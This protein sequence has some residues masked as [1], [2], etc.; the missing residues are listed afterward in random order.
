MYRKSLGS[1]STTV[2]EIPPASAPV[3]NNVRIFV[4]RTLEITVHLSPGEVMPAVAPGGSPLAAEKTPQCRKH[5]FLAALCHI[6]PVG[7]HLG[8]LVTH[9]PCCQWQPCLC[10]RMM[11]AFRSL[12][13][14]LPWPR[15]WPVEIAC[16]IALVGHFGTDLGMV[17]RVAAHP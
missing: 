4:P 11:W 7:W 1:A 13:S 14:F 17:P 5:G 6:L 10:I 15:L 3:S 8:T 16:C 9:V 2:E 12:G